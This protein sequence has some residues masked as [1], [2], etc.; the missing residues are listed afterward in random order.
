MDVFLFSLRARDGTRTRDPDLGKV[1]LHPQSH[2]RMC[3]FLN[4]KVQYTNINGSCQSFFE[5][6]YFPKHI[7]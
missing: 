3:L 6:T 1:V 4:D 2:S 5:K 7:F